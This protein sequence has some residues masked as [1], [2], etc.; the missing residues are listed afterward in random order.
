MQPTTPTQQAWHEK[1]GV[2]LAVGVGLALVC[3]L[4]LVLWITTST[5]FVRAIG[6][7][8]GAGAFY[9]IYGGLTGLRENRD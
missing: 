6:L 7:A 5:F 1:P 2:C 3:L 9:F 4:S 8:S